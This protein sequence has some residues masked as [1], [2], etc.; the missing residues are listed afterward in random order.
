MPN[1]IGPTSLLYF[2]ILEKI[3]KKTRRAKTTWA[4][5]EV[6]TFRRTETCLTDHTESAFTNQ[7]HIK[8]NVC[9]MHH[10]S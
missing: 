2:A 10:A 4:K 5:I 1:P 9:K 8:M 7:T 3:F 6:Y